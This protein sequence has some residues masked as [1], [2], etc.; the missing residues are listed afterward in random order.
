[1][2]AIERLASD[3]EKTLSV[4][5]IAIEIALELHKHFSGCEK[6]VKKGNLGLFDNEHSTFKHFEIMQKIGL[7]ETES[8]YP[9]LGLYKYTERARRFYQ[10][11]KDE[12]CYQ[13][14]AGLHDSLKK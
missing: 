8:E 12:G 10:E 11:L 14:L 7:I 4:K 9:H 13:K 5:I 3:I 6:E 1:M 2:K